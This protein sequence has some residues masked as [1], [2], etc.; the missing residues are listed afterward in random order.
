[1]KKFFLLSL[2][3]FSFSQAASPTWNGR[4]FKVKD[5]QEITFSQLKEELS[6][7]QLIALGENHS[8]QEVQD[9]QAKVISEVVMHTSTQNNFT[10]AWEFLNVKDQAK[11]DRN[12]SLLKEGKITTQEFIDYAMA[13]G[14]SYRPYAPVI[15]SVSKLSG[16]LLGINLTRQE[17]SPVTRGGISAANPDLVPP[18]YEIGGANYFNRFKAEMGGHD[19]EENTRNYFD[20][21]C[22]TDD[23]MAF[24]TLKNNNTAK[25]F[26]IAGHFHT[27]Y[28]DG[29]VQRLAVR[30]P[31]L[32]KATVRIV[33]A[34]DYTPE[35]ISPMMHD[36]VY[37][38]VSD[39]VVYVKEPYIK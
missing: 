24:H 18:G 20:S 39:Y 32:V 21:Q 27:D 3:S 12:F 16:T 19:S 17:K 6:A 15:E 29:V 35:Q 8:T 13:G 37:G 23:V 26:L 2:F 4:V 5:G 38:D 11:T 34:S 30:A 7:Y 28:N 31:N 10:L 36:S 22:L 14:N 25:T 9:M 1:M 33:D